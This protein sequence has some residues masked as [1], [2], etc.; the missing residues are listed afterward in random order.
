[1]SNYETNYVSRS[2]EVVAESPVYEMYLRNI[3]HK[4]LIGVH[5]RNIVK[6]SSEAS[7]RMDARLEGVDKIV[8]DSIR[9]L[10]SGYGRNLL[11]I[12]AVIS[13]PSGKVDISSEDSL[14]TY[15]IGSVVGYRNFPT[16]QLSY[17]NWSDCLVNNGYSFK[18]NV[19]TK[20]NH[21]F[22]PKKEKGKLRL[23]TAP[24][25]ELKAM[26]RK[27]N[28]VF[29]SSTKGF[30]ENIL[31]YSPGSDYVKTLAEK[32]LKY[33]H[34]INFD[35]KNFFHQMCG[36]TLDSAISNLVLKQIEKHI[37]L[38]KFYD[39]SE[40]S[41]VN[42]FKT[43]FEDEIKYINKMKNTKV[44][45]QVAPLFDSI[46]SS[47]SVLLHYGSTILK[48]A[49]SSNFLEENCES[50]RAL[51][52]YAWMNKILLDNL[53]ELG[54]E[55]YLTSTTYK[56]KHP[57][58]ELDLFAKAFDS[59]RKIKLGE[60]ISWDMRSIPAAA[61]INIV[62]KKFKGLI[63]ARMPLNYEEN[64]RSVP[65][66]AVEFDGMTIEDTTEKYGGFAEMCQHS[67]EPMSY[68][69]R[70]TGARPTFKS[71]INKF[72][73]SLNW[74][75][76]IPQGA[77]TSGTLAN[78]LNDIVYDDLRKSLKDSGF[79]A[80]FEVMIYSDNIY[81]FYNNAEEYANGA[82]TV[83]SFISKEVNKTFQKHGLK[84]NKEKEM[85]FDKRDKKMLGILIDDQGEIRVSR[86][87]RRT[88]NQ[89]IINLN[90]HEKINYKGITYTRKDL[91]R[92]KGL[93]NWLNRPGNNG[94]NRSLIPMTF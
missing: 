81:I 59:V 94:Y 73:K 24:K 4:I 48:N 33:D 64:V 47:S 6:P 56:L 46:W 39:T 41:T 10:A 35:V 11:S 78:F 13:T 69:I 54:S 75:T 92:V 25:T 38:D 76:A 37:P 71:F 8:V 91:R 27:L 14:N 34:M 93:I 70:K 2:E 44:P 15:F 88:I 40:Q 18:E 65:I 52:E 31:A 58:N 53:S 5:L 16:Y 66:S 28:S 12:N 36:R 20:Y 87:T 86:A 68:F 42:N 85:F 1:M 7:R 19:G 51:L 17:G 89:I 30:P 21:F 45:I 32:Q 90:K 62:L 77:P 26:Q 63:T 55:A 84:L 57:I 60:E 83:A 50:R 67:P 49:E 80:D 9:S 29:Y 79:L 72:H 3:F 61:S 23:I 74:I 22:I 82:F 43:L